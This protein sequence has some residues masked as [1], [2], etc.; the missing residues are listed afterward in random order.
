MFSI[1]SFH[2]QIQHNTGT[3]PFHIEVSKMVYLVITISVVIELDEG[4]GN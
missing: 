4:V 3:S 2:S 1:T